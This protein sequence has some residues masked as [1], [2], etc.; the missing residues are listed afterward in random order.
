MKYPRED[1]INGRIFRILGNICIHKDQ[2]A[3]IVIDKASELV[4]HGIQLL[5]NFSKENITDQK[6]NSEATVIMILRSLR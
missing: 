1:S 2:W 3:S 6:M 4:M 5:K